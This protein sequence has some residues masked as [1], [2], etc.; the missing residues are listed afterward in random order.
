[1]YS[2]QIREMAIGKPRFGY[3]E[4]RLNVIL[5]PIDLFE[6]GTSAWMAAQVPESRPL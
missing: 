1:M 4:A 2:I 5:N 3:S 6:V